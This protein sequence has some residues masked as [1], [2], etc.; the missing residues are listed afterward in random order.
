MQNPGRDPK[1][2]FFYKKPKH[3]T[4][5]KSKLSLSPPHCVLHLLVVRLGLRITVLRER[6]E[7]VHFDLDFVQFSSG[8]APLCEDLGEAVIVVFVEGPMYEVM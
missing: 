6:F 3:H 8:E 2:V 5:N 7:H 4:V 1:R